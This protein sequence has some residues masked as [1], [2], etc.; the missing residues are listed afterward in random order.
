MPDEVDTVVE[1]AEDQAERVASGGRVAE[2][3]TG[4]GRFPV[5]TERGEVAIPSAGLSVD[6]YCVARLSHAAE[7][8]AES[9]LVE[10]QIGA[11]LAGLTMGRFP[12]AKESTAI[13]WAA[14]EAGWA[15]KQNTRPDSLVGDRF[16]RRDVLD[17][18]DELGR[19]HV[20]ELVAALLVLAAPRR[21]LVEAIEE[22]QKEAGVAPLRETYKRVATGG[23]IGVDSAELWSQLA[24]SILSASGHS[25]DIKP[26]N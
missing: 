8:M 3:E 4:E 24:L 17:I 1:G 14:L 20:D 25:P 7:E 10:R 9:L 12:T 21:E 22:A 18:F 16:K 19:V 26:P 6:G 15:D 2:S 11:V 5:N 23:R 13:L